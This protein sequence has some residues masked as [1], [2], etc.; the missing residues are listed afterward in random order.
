MFAKELL[1]KALGLKLPGG[2]ED[3]QVEGITADSRKVKPG[4]IFVAVPGTKVDGASFAGQALEQGAKL[5]VSHK[6]IEGICSLVVPNAN[7][8][9][10]KLGWSFFG[11]DEIQKRG[12]LSL[13]GVTGTN[14]KTT[15]C[16]LFQYFANQF[17]RTCARFGTVEYDLVKTKHQASHTTPDTIQLAGLIR[18]AYD[19]GA[20]SIVM[21]VSSH[22]LDQGRAAGLKFSTAAFS[23]LTGDHL[24]Y[25]GTMENY[26]EAKLGLFKSLGSEG[27]AIVNI[28][29]P[30]GGKV[31]AACGGRKISYGIDSFQADL[32]A[33]DLK[34]TAA[35]TQGVMRFGEKALPFRSPFIGKHNVYNV[36]AAVGSG[37]GSG[38]DFGRLVELIEK[39]P[40]VPGRLERV[41]NQA[42]FEVFVDYAHTDDGLVNVLS[43]LK[44]LV[45]HKL[46]VV[47]GCGGDRDRTKRPR[48]AAVAEKYADT[49]FVTSD[50]PRTED[51]TLIIQE[52]LAGFSPSFQPKVQVEPDRGSAIKMAL[53]Q[54]QP[55]DIV[56]LAGKGHEDYQ[57]IGTTKIHF[58][59]REQC[60]NFFG[61]M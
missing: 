30:A 32:A 53:G 23:N 1:G 47:F 51:P 22:A 16:Y 27:C 41:A 2:S 5:I 8:A 17:G 19:N 7:L 52:I 20:N 11:I 59:D 15:F 45:T 24:D 26:L 37:I 3:F 49:V 40:D 55:G 57:I 46:I 21:E 48:M 50:N 58:D 14:G 35:G 9:L 25:H 29:D 39:L 28:D 18:Q 12:L 6:Q 10:A 54:A 44:P 31:L 33:R 36:L 42:G 61:A 38:F 4:S 43:S 56:L 60:R 13:H 34:M